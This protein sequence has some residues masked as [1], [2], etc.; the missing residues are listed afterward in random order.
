MDVE[1]DYDKEYNSSYHWFM[2][3]K[4]QFKRLGDTEYVRYSKQTP[5]CKLEESTLGPIKVSKNETSLQ[6][7]AAQNPDVHAGGYWAPRHCRA[8]QRVAIIIPYRNRRVNLAIFLRYI[9]PLLKKQLLE[10][11][12][13]VIEQSGTEKFNKGTLYN[14]AFL[15]TQRFSTWH[16]LIFHDVDLIPEDERIPYSCP[17]YP[18]HLAA[19][20]EIFSYTLP[21]RKIFG[22]VTA[23]TPKHYRKVNGYSNFYWDWGAED[24]DFHARLKSKK[25]PVLRYNGSIARYATLSHTATARGK[26]RHL[27]LM[28]S[29]IRSRKEGLAT[30]IYKL[31]EVKEEKLYTRILADVNPK[32][33]KLDMKSVM[34]RVLRLHGETIVYGRR[35]FILSNTAF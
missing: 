21:Y 18:T 20:V 26:E 13:F 28:L 33:L 3:R 14:I 23:L 15:E 1:M 7:V 34:Q 31:L 27:L 30:T 11:R 25:L 8:A 12:I 22:G 17:K 2:K 24:D 35:E 5:I 19:A 9:Y 32:R 4:H 6:W 10:Y 29:I 16:C